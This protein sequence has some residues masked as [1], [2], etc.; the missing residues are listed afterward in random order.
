MASTEEA[1]VADAPTSALAS[2]EM[3]EP[4]LQ[5]VDSIVAAAVAAAEAELHAV[6]EGAAPAVP[7]AER[8][9]K[10]S[11][12]EEE[13]M[14]A[15]LMSNPTVERSGVALTNWERFARPVELAIL[16]LVMLLLVVGRAGLDWARVGAGMSGLR[17]CVRLEPPRRRCAL[18][19][20]LSTSAFC[21][22]GSAQA[23][24]GHPFLPLHSSCAAG[25][26]A[27]AFCALE[28]AGAW[29]LGLSGAALLAGVLLGAA[30]ATQ[31]LHRRGK[32]GAV[33]EGLA[34][35]AATFERA[36]LLTPPLL[37]VLLL[38]LLFLTLLVYAARVSP[39]LA[40]AALAAAALAAAA[41]AAALAAAL[42]AS[43]LPRRL[44]LLTS[45]PRRCA[46]AL[47]RARHGAARP[48][49]RLRAP[50]AAARRGGRGAARRLPARGRA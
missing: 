17:A 19:R 12:F 27:A 39:A 25:E 30:T 22:T 28:G 6:Q 46:G 20:A 7:G 8:E 47:R 38:L 11:T 14:A 42:D 35:P 3:P 2:A 1:G 4:N 18:S 16:S 13:D 26:E 43:A 37:W 34:V 10:L 29:A 50:R 24:S 41:A 5:Q 40:A 21:H 31:E 48:L 15:S 32:L 49:V 9:S 36:M 23:S 44:F 33:A 45:R